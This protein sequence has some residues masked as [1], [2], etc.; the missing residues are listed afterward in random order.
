MDDM[1]MLLFDAQVETDKSKIK[2]IYIVGGVIFVI[3]VGCAV[4][5]KL[6]WEEYTHTIYNVITGETSRGGL[7]SI[8]YSWGLIFAVAIPLIYGLMWFSIDFKNPALGVNKNGVFINQ[9]G[10][11]KAFLKWNEIERIEKRG[12]NELRI[13]MKNPE[14]VV[15]RQPAAMRPFLTQTFVKDRSPYLLKSSS[16]TDNSRK[17]VEL[18]GKYSGM[19]N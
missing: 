2:K 11:K 4:W 17:V 5:A 10:F 15:K 16:E 3:A 14:E 1:N 12:E 8:L 6:N 19:V 7:A 9:E 18:V 13:Y